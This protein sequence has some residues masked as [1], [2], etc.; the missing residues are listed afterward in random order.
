MVYDPNRHHRR[1]IRLPGYDYT[2]PGAYFITICTQDRQCLFGE[3]ADG[4]VV[5]NAAGEMVEAVWNGLPDRFPEISTDEFIVMPNH[6]HGIIWNVG[7]PLVGA[8]DP[9]N[10]EPIQTRASRLGAAIGAFKSQTTN[11]YIHGVNTHGWSAFRGRLWQR[12][13]YERIIRNEEELQRLRG[14]MAGN[15]GRW[16]RTPGGYC[17]PDSGF[18][19]K[20]GPFRTERWFDGVVPFA[21]GVD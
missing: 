18:Q 14:Y 5:L 12:N 15:P 3:I 4:K 16:L 11:A 20:A 9:P 6:F 1:S 8:L 17:L 2:S 7:A 19:S 10:P 21:G 13:Y